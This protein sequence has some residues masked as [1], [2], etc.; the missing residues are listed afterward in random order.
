MCNKQCN[1]CPWIE[2]SPFEIK[3]WQNYIK[4]KVEEGVLSSP[5]HRCHTLTSKSHN[6]DGSEPTDDVC[7]GSLQYK[8][9]L[10]NLEV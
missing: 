10:E 1:K 7:Q 2:D 4:S 3:L 9:S 5:V 8:K 6:E